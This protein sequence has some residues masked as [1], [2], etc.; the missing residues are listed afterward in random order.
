MECA[1]PDFARKAL[2]LETPSASS[3]RN[4]SRSPWVKLNDLLLQRFTLAKQRRAN[5]WLVA[6]PDKSRTRTPLLR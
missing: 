4:T 2:R 6:L 3:R 1:C 5:S